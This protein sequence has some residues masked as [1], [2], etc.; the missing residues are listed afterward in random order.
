MDAKRTA[1]L[2]IGFQNDY[3]SPQGVLHS[4]I[5]Q[6]ARVTNTLE[7]TLYVVEHLVPTETLIITTPILF[8]ANYEE[9]VE[10]VGILRTIRDSGAFKAGSPGGQTV[11]ELARYGDRLF[12]VPGKRG[13]NAFS[14]TRLEEVLKS[15]AVTDV[16]IC[17]VVASICIDSTGR[18]AFERGYRVHVLA[19]CISGR[20]ILEQ[21]FY[22]SQIFPLYA[23]VA[24]SREFVSALNA[25]G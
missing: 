19:D 23:A 2:L 21:D 9:L 5:E 1:L 16:A 7:N 18:G 3:F 14:N 12:E 20:T 10:P 17:G 8:T 4:V 15:H 22:I 6:P 11:P 13:L 24:T 25:A